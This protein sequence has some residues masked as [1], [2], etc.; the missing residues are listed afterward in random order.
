M[1]HRRNMES[2]NDADTWIYSRHSARFAPVEPARARRA[3]QTRPLP[4]TPWP[5][6][7]T[8]ARDLRDPTP[9]LAFDR[10]PRA[11]LPEA[12]PSWPLEPVR[13]PA[14]PAPRQSRLLLWLTSIV[15][16]IA[17]SVA[18]YLAALVQMGD[19]A[20]YGVLR[21]AR[22]V[23]DA[24]ST[25][26]AQP[27]PA[28]AP[29]RADSA[30]EPTAQPTA[31][32]PTPNTQ[33]PRREHANAP[34]PTAAQPVHQQRRSPSSHAQASE[35]AAPE[36]SEPG[37][38]P[39]AAPDNRRAPEASDEPPV[40]QIVPLGP[41]VDAN[42]SA[43]PDDTDGEVRK[44][45]SRDDV[46]RGLERVRPQLVACAG[47]RHGTTYSQITISHTGRVTYSLIEGAFAGTPEGSCMAR[48]LRTAR[49][50]RSAADS[51]TVRYP[52]RF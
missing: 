24:L 31:P 18:G 1:N 7:P 3:R 48:A 33:L 5:M 27:A 40:L 12:Q 14:A 50:P 13:E 4:P 32:R 20:G 17:F 30:T 42:A 15:C 6:A 8:P 10:V 47:D 23:V 25:Q 36:P 41:A 9:R 16:A 49:F 37:S 52:F 28:T 34:P 26:P 35:M 22:P 51:I 44:D 46:Q 11:P 39:A 21:P 2:D 43:L 45:L 38:T 29:L 19:H